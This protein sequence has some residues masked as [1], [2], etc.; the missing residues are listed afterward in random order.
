MSERLRVDL[1][2]EDRA[3]EEFLDPLLRR[4]AREESVEV[5]VRV[6]SA[7]GGHARAIAEFRLYQ[8]LAQKGAL[9]D[10]KPDLVV[11]GID[12]NCTTFARKRSE[13]ESATQPPFRD[14]L[15]V[16]CPDP[17]VERWFLGD[18]QSFEMV[19]G[20]QPALGKRKCARGHYKALL[21]KAVRLGGHPATLGGIEFAR[22]IADGLDFY[23]AGKSNPSFGAFMDDLRG[24]LRRLRKRRGRAPK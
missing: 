13:I 9:G 14:K 19:V 1:F 2:V 12:G 22:E 20:H 18:P 24:A 11:V 6:R 15:V 17:H 5:A 3:H 4:I 16:A 23:R 10:D 7:R 8:T 21:A